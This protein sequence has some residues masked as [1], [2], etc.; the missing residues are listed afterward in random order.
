MTG[1]SWCSAAYDESFSRVGALAVVAICRAATNSVE[2]DCTSTSLPPNP[3]QVQPA[4]SWCLAQLRIPIAASGDGNMAQTPVVERQS[5]APAIVWGL[6]Y[7]PAKVS[8]GHGAQDFDPDNI[9]CFLHDRPIGCQWHLDDATAFREEK[10]LLREVELDGF[11]DERIWLI[12]D[13][14][15]PNATAMGIVSSVQLQN[16]ILIQGLLARH[17]CPCL[18]LQEMRGFLV[19]R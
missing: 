17:L 14:I 19:G 5:S 12:G 10:G 1:I 13:A 18:L 8:L 6:T 16:Q 2:I 11:R 4:A 9:R 15:H 7:D 3:N